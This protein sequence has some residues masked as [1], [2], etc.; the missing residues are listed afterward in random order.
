M[1]A[2]H[3]QDFDIIQLNEMLQSLQLQLSEVSQRLARVE[4]TV[5]PS[6]PNYKRN[7]EGNATFLGTKYQK[8]ELELETAEGLESGRFLG[9]NY[10]RS[11]AKVAM[12]SD[13]TKRTFLGRE[14]SGQ[15]L[16]R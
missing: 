11:A 10:T 2:T 3:S 8:P 15:T 9:N 13:G 5:A 14:F 16:D 6:S 1:N 7:N 12:K 4:G